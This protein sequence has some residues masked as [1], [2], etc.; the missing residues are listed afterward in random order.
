M[1]ENLV[2]DNRCFSPYEEPSGAN[3]YDVTYNA[4]N[5]LLQTIADCHS[6]ITIGSIMGISD[7]TQYPVTVPVAQQS[8]ESAVMTISKSN[9]ATTVIFEYDG[10]MWFNHYYS[11]TGGAQ[12]S[13]WKKVNTAEDSGWSILTLYGGITAASVGAG[14]PKIRKIGNHV[15]IRGSVTFTVPSTGTTTIADLPINR[16]PAVACYGLMACDD[17]RIAQNHINTAGEIIND[18][19]V[20]VT[21]G[22]R[23]TGTIDWL[24]I[25]MDFFTD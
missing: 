21:D 6:G 2:K 25:S 17:N 16:R 23:Y 8:T 4:S 24:D 15:F 20:N 3:A 10:D 22:S 12:L 11:N 18:Y 19:V 7:T 9:R 13:G 5:T 1:S 14:T